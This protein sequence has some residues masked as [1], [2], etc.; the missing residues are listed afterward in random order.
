MEHIIQFGVTID[1]DKI[2]SHIEAN[3][4][5]AVVDQFLNEMKSKLP[6]HYY[7]VNWNQV[8]NDAVADFIEKNKD[9]VLQ[10]LTDALIARV[11]RTKA[12]KEAVERGIALGEE[13]Q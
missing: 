11:G 2:R 3:A 7:G 6:H 8:A 5:Q 1:D 4:M 12:Y 10:K 13:A 9:V